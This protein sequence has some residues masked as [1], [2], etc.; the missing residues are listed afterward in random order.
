M[1][2]ERIVRTLNLIGY[3]LLVPGP[4]LLFWNMRAVLNGTHTDGELA[5]MLVGF[6][7]TI[8]GLILGNF[9]EYWLTE[10]EV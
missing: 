3:V 4:V 5:L 8:L 1:K 6:V 2:V 9:K 10:E 7:S